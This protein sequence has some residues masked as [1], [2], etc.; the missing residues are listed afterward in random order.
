LSRR[1]DRDRADAVFADA[2]DVVLREGV[3]S[4]LHGAL[5]DDLVRARFG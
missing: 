3:G 4:L 5:L 2:L 1:R